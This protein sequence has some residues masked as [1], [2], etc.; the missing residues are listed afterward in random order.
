MYSILETG[1]CCISVCFSSSAYSL[2]A[3]LRDAMPVAR[4]G[5]S[6]LQR[7]DHISVPVALEPNYVSL[8]GSDFVYRLP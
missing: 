8:E 6:I 1:K 7:A 5:C 3:T 2:D 4:P